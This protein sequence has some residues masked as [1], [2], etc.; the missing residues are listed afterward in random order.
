MSGFTDVSGFAFIS[1]MADQMRNIFGSVFDWFTSSLAGMWDSVKGLVD[2]IPGIGG[3]EIESVSRIEAVQKAKPKVQV[4]QGGAAKSIANYA[5][6]Q[7]HYGGI[8]IYPAQM[9]NPQDLAFE[10]EMAA[11]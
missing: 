9:S 7:T 2:W 10:L 1:E 6:S 11:G 4:Q 3:D 5:G 8:A